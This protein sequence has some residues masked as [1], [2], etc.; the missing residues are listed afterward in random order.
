[1][2]WVGLRGAGVDD[3]DVDGMLM[4]LAFATGHV[5]WLVERLGWFVRGR[6]DGREGMGGKG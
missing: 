5:Y 6:V 2:R 4:G 1:M 3:G